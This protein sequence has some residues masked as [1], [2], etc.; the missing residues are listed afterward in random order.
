VPRITEAGDLKFEILNKCRKFEILNNN[1]N[2]NNCKPTVIIEFGCR[3][4]SHRGFSFGIPSCRA[5]V[6]GACASR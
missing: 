6:E 3:H 5:L 2:N 1:N 4:K